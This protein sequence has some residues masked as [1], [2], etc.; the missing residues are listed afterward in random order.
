MQTGAATLGGSSAISY[1]T[2]HNGYFNS[3]H[4][5]VSY[6]ATDLK[7]PKSTCEYLYHLYSLLPH[8]KQ[9]RYPSAGY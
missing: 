6:F 2:E 4:G 7:T 1:K 8:K 9:P 5:A 3:S